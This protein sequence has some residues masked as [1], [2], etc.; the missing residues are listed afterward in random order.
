MQAFEEYRSGIEV[1]KKLGCELIEIRMPHTDYAIAA[2]YIIATAERARTWRGMMECAMAC[3]WRTIPCWRCTGRRAAAVWRRGE[4][5]HCARY[6]RAFGR[7]LRRLLPEGAESSR[8]DSA[9]FRDAFT[10]VDAI[11]TP[12]L[13]P[14][15]QIGGAD[16]RSLQMY[17]ADILQLRDLWRGSGDLRGLAERSTEAARGLQISGRRLA[18][19]GCCS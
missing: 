6:V 7:L 12:T 16:E 10:K 14:S 5:A 11:L 3:A 4:T 13:R 17:L 1:Y 8:A 15:L 19:C 2:Y 18:R 9:G